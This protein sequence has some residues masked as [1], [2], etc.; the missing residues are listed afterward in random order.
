MPYKSQ[1]GWHVGLPAR[2]NPLEN[3]AGL[4]SGVHATVFVKSTIFGDVT[5]CSLVEFTSVK[6]NLMTLSSRSKRKSKK[7][8]P[9][10]WLPLPL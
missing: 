5:P 1:A 9:F 6:D 2:K 7:R 4:R 3:N 10:P 8:S